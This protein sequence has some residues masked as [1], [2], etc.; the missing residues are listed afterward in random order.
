M[1]TM[2]VSDAIDISQEKGLK[3]CGKLENCRES[4]TMAGLNF[5]VNKDF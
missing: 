5:E 4:L 2:K 1:P 3:S